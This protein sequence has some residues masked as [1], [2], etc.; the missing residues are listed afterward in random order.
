MCDPWVARQTLVLVPTTAAAAHLRRTLEQALTESRANANAWTMPHLLTR[1]GW[2]RAMH[3]RLSDAPIL[4]TALERQVCMLAAARHTVQANV[5]PPFRLRAGLAQSFL[6]FYDELRSQ[7]QTV[8]AFERLLTEDLGPSVDLD[9]GARRLLR[10]TRFLAA[11][12]RTYERRLAE[13][14]SFDEHGLRAYLG[15]APAT[16]FER[17]VVTLPDHVADAAGLWPADYDLLS[18]LPGLKQI[19]VV[20]TESVLSAGFHERLVERLPG[21][22]VHTVGDR[23]SQRPSLIGPSDDCSYF[24]W[25]DR[26]EELRA[27]IR[28]VKGLGR[29]T[30]VTRHTTLSNSASTVSAQVGVVY[31]RPLPYLY[32]ARQLFDQAGVPFE[33]RDT[34]PLASEPY[35]AALD[36]VCEFALSGFD[37]SSTV[38]L[39]GSP[40]FS[41]SPDAEILRL[42][43]VECLDRALREVRF[44]SGH[45]EL[46][47]LASVWTRRDHGSDK[48]RPETRQITV[49]VGL[50]SELH[51]LENEGPVHAMLELLGGFLSRYSTFCDDTQAVGEREQ[52]ARTAILRGIDD[53]ASAHRQLNR[54]HTSFSNVVSIL[55]R[56]LETQTFQPTPGGGGVQLL[57]PYAAAYGIFDELTIV[58]VVDH[59]WPDLVGRN[60]FYPSFLLRPLGWPSEQDRYRS[61]R[62]A[63]FD[64][65]ALP[66]RRVSI[67][68]FSFED[69]AIVLP[70]SLLEDLADAGLEAVRTDV[71]SDMVVTPDDALSR[72][73]DTSYHPDEPTA[74]WVAARVQHAGRSDSSFHGMV[75]PRR[76]TTYAVKALDD[77]LECPFKFFANHVLRLG[78]EPADE[79]R[80]DPQRR[81]LFLHGVLKAFF[82]VW[83]DEGHLAITVSTFDRAVTRFHRIAEAELSTLPVLDRA[84]MRSWILGSAAA[85]SLAERLLLWEVG[86]PAEL[87]ERKLEIRLDADYV[88]TGDGGCRTVKLRGVA[89]RVDLFSNGTF[90]VVDYKANRAP[91]RKRTLQLPL[92]ARC[93][94]QELTRRDGRQWRAMDVAYAAFGEPRLHRPLS[95]TEIGNRLAADERRAVV[96]VDA[97]E[98]GEYPVRPAELFGCNFCAYPTVCRKNYV[99]DK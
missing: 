91:D 2:Y 77:Y 81:G 4:L 13:A 50:A 84:V 73:L 37:R 66:R 8:D 79:Q 57:D 41:F 49:A 60:I 3:E 26:E 17:V 99:G 23:S 6:Q 38:A 44:S 72:G 25:R 11:T 40:H 48:Q 45:R 87:I 20:A 78:D 98:H 34:L 65:L 68:T 62:A 18:R 35:A 56:W 90:R 93:L 76:P 69:D 75:G 14:G 21:I 61:A 86:R 7:R 9:R 12:F 46:A 24:V 31:Q 63:F 22:N 88:L 5:V 89:D 10:Q 67:S 27:V 74:S 51:P 97:I 29:G 19:D 96:V 43:T 70:S 52:R 36:L 33:S 59:E 32:L 71:D 55:R 42:S 1:E 64:L 94:E 15:D 95:R 83:Q 28:S 47:G 85:A 54:S 16:G 82:R 80:A 92:Y 53:L 58:G 39:L 30:S